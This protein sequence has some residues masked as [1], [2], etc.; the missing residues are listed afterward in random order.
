MII[1]TTR[2]RLSVYQGIKGI[3]SQQLRGLLN[4]FD[5]FANTRLVYT[6]RVLVRSFLLC[7]ICFLFLPLLSVAYPIVRYGR[8]RVVGLNCASRVS[9]DS[10]SSSEI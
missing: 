5:T 10:F 6:L 1:Y 9:V 4:N 8:S 3:L 7:L 2:H